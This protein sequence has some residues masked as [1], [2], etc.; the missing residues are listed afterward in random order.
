MKR[1]CLRTIGFGLCLG[2]L[3]ASAGCGG[4]VNEE[5]NATFLK[6][7]GHTSV[8]VYPAFVRQKQERSHEPRAAEAIGVFLADEGLATVTVSQE[9]VPITGGWHMNQAR[10]LRESAKDFAKYVAEHDI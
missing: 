10:M 5:A 1:W 4:I 8:T 2:A 3:W 7:L 9:Q 6:T